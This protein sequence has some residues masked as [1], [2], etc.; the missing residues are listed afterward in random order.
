MTEPFR[1]VVQFIVYLC[2]VLVGIFLTRLSDEEE[3][4]L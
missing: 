1:I 3:S 4:S 2:G